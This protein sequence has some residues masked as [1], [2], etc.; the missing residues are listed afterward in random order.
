MVSEFRKM[1]FLIMLR[2]YLL[3]KINENP[4]EFRVLTR[5]VLQVLSQPA[6]YLHSTQ[7]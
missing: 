6:L 5:K 4:I 1:V 3:H 2:M 7:P